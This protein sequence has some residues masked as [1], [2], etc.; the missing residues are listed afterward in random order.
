MD[1]FS[2]SMP[3]VAEK[4]TKMF[5]DILAKTNI[6]EETDSMTNVDVQDMVHKKKKRDINVLK[7]KIKFVSK[8]AKMQKILREENE[9]IIKIKVGFN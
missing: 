6:Q 9:N 4:V 1:V 2:W 5:F 7:N 3:F 8:M